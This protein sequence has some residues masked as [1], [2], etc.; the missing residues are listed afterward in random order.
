[1]GA[2]A[3]ST[4]AVRVDNSWKF[5]DPGVRYVNPG[6]SRWQAEGGEGLIIDQSP[7]WVMTPISPPEKSRETRV[8]TL[9]LDE[10]GTLEGDV[11][12][13]FTGHLAIIKKEQND[14][15]SPNQ[16]E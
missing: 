9:R 14:D 15:D 12:I 4:I 10:D 11:S 7:T 1:P 16:R 8:A 3:W 13:E 2:L 5:F 6:M